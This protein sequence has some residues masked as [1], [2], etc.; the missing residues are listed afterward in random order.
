M[1]RG[2]RE[3]FQATKRLLPPGYRKKL[4]KIYTWGGLS[5]RFLYDEVVERFAKKQ[6]YNYSVVVCGLTKDSEEYILNHLGKLQRMEEVFKEF[7]FV[8]YEND[9][10]DDTLSKL[11]L[12]KSN[13]ENFN[14]ISEKNV[15]GRVTGWDH[16]RHRIAV[17]AHG[18]NTLLDYVE[19]NFQNYDFMIMVDLDDIVSRF[20]VHQLTHLFGQT[21]HWDALTAN[22]YGYRDYY[23]LW[24]LRFHRRQ[25]PIARGSW[26]DSY[27][28]NHNCHED[29]R[30]FV[31]C[32]KGEMKIKI[33]RKTKLIPVL[34]AFGGFAIYRMEKIKGCRFNS[35]FNGGL[36]CDPVAF[37]NDMREKHDAKIFICPQFLVERLP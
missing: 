1:G 21:D 13:H 20:R 27:C 32:I 15:P 2:T 9:S 18:R 8:V 6:M 17:I 37:H 11:E 19:S 35:I 10:S 14:F 22:T 31:K 29:F 36:D 3:I 23:D 34:S 12:F 33:P 7:H 26:E 16:G 25:D 5:P 28:A 30:K 4:R 24:A